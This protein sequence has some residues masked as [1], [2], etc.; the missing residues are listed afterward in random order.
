MNYYINESNSMNDNYE[1]Q[2]LKSRNKILSG[3][4]KFINYLNYV[5]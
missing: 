1:N 2:I 5:L 4:S 3:F